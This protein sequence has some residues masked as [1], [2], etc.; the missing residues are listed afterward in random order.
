MA[1]A[2][3]IEL[4]SRR[5]R[6][7]AVVRWLDAAW[8]FVRRWPVVPGIAITGLLIMAIF[9]PLIAP[10]DPV[11]QNLRDSMAPP[12]WDT[13]WYEA[14]PKAAKHILGA[15]FFGRD[16][17]SRV[18]YG[19]RISLMLASIALASG[20]IL[21]AWAGMIAGY[22]GGIIDE[23]IARFV[24][25][26]SSIPFLLI[27]LVVSV[28]IGQG[29]AI[30]I[31]LLVLLT[32]VAMVRNVRAEALSLK[33]RDYVALARIAGASDFRI[34]FRHILPGTTNLLL[35]LA[36]SRVG[37]LILTEA[38][39]SFLGV[40]VP[41]HIPTWGIMISDGR[42]FLN[43]AWWVS[44]FPGIG[45]FLTVMSLNFLG[46]WIRDRTDPRLRQLD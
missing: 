16:V 6:R 38:S 18:I 7:F 42:M 22:Y 45:I 12:L 3:E 39:L 43:T 8:H 10:M 2:S 4:G 41:S 33:T 30:M 40:G 5:P 29:L 23:L 46:D 34:M 14:H 35:I 13:A 32:W 1:I 28:T 9:A 25:I 27:A 31:F 17:L 24:D 26:W 36:S 21:A 44:V 11:A 15:D 37:A 20:V 19:A